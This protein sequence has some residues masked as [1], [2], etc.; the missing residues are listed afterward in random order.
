[1]GLV[2]VLAWATSISA[3]L[4]TERARG[5][6]KDKI[7]ARAVADECAPPAYHSA[8]LDWTAF[9]GEVYEARSLV[10]SQ[11]IGQLAGHLE[12][13]LAQAQLEKLLNLVGQSFGLTSQCPA[14]LATTS[15]SLAEVLAVNA[16]PHTTRKQ[17]ALLQLALAAF[18]QKAHGECTQW[19]LRGRDIVAGFSQLGTMLFP[20][21]PAEEQRSHSKVA[22]VS[23]C[24]GLHGDV[25]RFTAQENFGIYAHRHGY[26]LHFFADAREL[27]NRYH[28][29]NLSSSNAPAFWRAYAMQVVLDMPI[30]YDWIMWIDCEAVVTDVNRN[31]DVILS[32]HGVPPDGQMLVTADGWGTQPWI[33]LLKGEPKNWSRNFLRNWT[34]LPSSDFLHGATRSP[35]ELR[36]P[37]R[38]ALQHAVLPHWHFWFEDIPF[39]DFGES[40]SWK[41]EIYLSVSTLVTFESDQGLEHAGGR[42]WESG[43][44]SWI[45]LQCHGRLGRAAGCENRRQHFLNSLG[46]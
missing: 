12:V 19:P 42:K 1:M 24:A 43:D 5:C 34:T 7:F 17:L 20:L 9:T 14:A 8:T 33:I 6:T 28:T 35:P 3:E 13:D 26:D 11:G 32:N 27:L 4:A 22:I 38:I 40:F 31:V 29:L 10:F 44:F 16:S 21:H 2:A 46:H 15:Y 39:L 23:A 30:V 25:V 18:P 37:E 36:H 41:S 45:N